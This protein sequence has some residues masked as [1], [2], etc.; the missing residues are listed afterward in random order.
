M[1]DSELDMKREAMPEYNTG[2][3]KIVTA[4]SDA[5]G[6][7]RW[8]LDIPR[9]RIFPNAQFTKEKFLNRMNPSGHIRETIVI[10][11]KL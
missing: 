4:R 3:A 7:A 6:F 11:R 1:A 5:N 9:R 8:R 2:V 10:N